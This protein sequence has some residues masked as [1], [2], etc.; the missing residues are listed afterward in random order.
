MKVSLLINMKMQIL[1]MSLLINMKMSTFV[2]IFIF[3]SI[4][5]FMLCWVE[6]EKSLKTPSPGIFENRVPLK[7]GATMA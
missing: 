3:I 4:E 2:G 5:N 7:A 1:K 6:H